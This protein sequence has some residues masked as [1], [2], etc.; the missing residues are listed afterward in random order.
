MHPL[1]MVL[2]MVVVLGGTSVLGSYVWGVTSISNVAEFW[3]DTP[4][5]L[6]PLY[7]VSMLLGAASFFAIL[8]FVLVK[9]NPPEVRI[10]ERFGYEA[11][12]WIML[13]ILVPSALW[14]PLVALMVAE[15]SEPVW[16]AIRVSLFVVGFA[17][18]ALVL[19]L[20]RIRPR[21]PV[22]AHRLAL[23]G[24]VVFT[25]HTLF[26]DALLWPAFFR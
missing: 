12:P 23:A 15:P 6:I 24:S 14:M 16:W 25:V 2:G 13:A 11:F 19:A 26:L 4:D 22:W 9:L 18:L 3:G 10:W 20:A 8:W 17:S 1:K 5:G 7:T 21:T